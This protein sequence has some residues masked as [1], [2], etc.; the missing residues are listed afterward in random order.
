MCSV[1]V[2]FHLEE[3][4]F[5]L[6][7]LVVIF[8]TLANVARLKLWIISFLCVIVPHMT[9]QYKTSTCSNDSGLKCM[10]MLWAI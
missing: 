2:K 3:V 6:H 1:V 8:W 9:E 10:F 4:Y 7:S 5:G